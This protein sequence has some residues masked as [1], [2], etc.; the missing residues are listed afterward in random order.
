[1]V[2]YTPIPALKY[3]LVYVVDSACRIYLLV[4]SCLRLFVQQQWQL[5]KQ[6]LRGGYC[7]YDGQDDPFNGANNDKNNMND[8]N[9]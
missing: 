5:L 7:S 2:T 6:F 3:R 8:N 9:Y 4:N 1:M